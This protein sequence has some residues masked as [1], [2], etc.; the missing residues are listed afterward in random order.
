MGGTWGQA[1]EG[2]ESLGDIEG[3]GG[4]SAQATVDGASCQAQV[5]VG[6][7]P[8]APWVPPLSPQHFCSTFLQSG[9][10]RPR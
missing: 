3:T 10:P 9:D 7:C 1:Q 5:H 4:R 2:G 8:R 6:S